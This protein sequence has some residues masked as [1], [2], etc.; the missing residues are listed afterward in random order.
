MRTAIK[1]GSKSVRCLLWVPVGILLVVPILSGKGSSLIAVENFG[2]ES[3]E[4][5]AE[6]VEIIEA[7][8][9][10]EAPSVL[11][12]VPDGSTETECSELAANSRT[13]FQQNTFKKFAG[14]IWVTMSHGI[15]GESLNIPS[16]KAVRV[17]SDC[18]N[19]CMALRLRCPAFVHLDSLFFVK[20]KAPGVCLHL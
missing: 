15:S 4:E 14:K 3:I 16:D 2:Q 11:P 10:I 8:E 6:N 7:I 9:A 1:N 13:G 12:N 20:E 5:V 18:R 17:C 19:S